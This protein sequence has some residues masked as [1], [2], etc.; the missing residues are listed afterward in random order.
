MGHIKLKILIKPFLWW[1]GRMMIRGRTR[2]GGSF[3]RRVDEW[4][5]EQQQLVDGDS[6]KEKGCTIGDGLPL[7]RRRP[8]YRD[9][10]CWH[11]FVAY[12]NMEWKRRNWVFST[13]ISLEAGEMW[14][15]RVLCGNGMMTRWWDIRGDSGWSP[16]CKEGERH[17][18]CLMCTTVM[19][20]I[21]C[22]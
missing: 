11:A 18:H 1:S 19:K 14:L 16:K 17:A 3:A 21:L 12:K 20:L 8:L 9:Q 4:K 7:S 22:H 13:S 2:N 5:I 6:G 10:Q 15:R